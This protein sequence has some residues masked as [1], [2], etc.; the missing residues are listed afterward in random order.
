MLESE[1]V[2]RY[3]RERQEKLD[4]ERIASA[5]EVL[6]YFTSIMRNEDVAI[7]ERTRCAENLS[8]QLLGDMDNDNK[9]VIQ[10]DIPRMPEKFKDVEYEEVEN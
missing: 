10:F 7:S 1:N 4:N 2:K 6:E 8:K 5:N 9:A 3:F